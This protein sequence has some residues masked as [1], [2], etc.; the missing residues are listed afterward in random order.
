MQLIKTKFD[1]N[2][3]ETTIIDNK[4]NATRLS[5]NYDKYYEIK[6]MKLKEEINNQINNYNLLQNK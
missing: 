5:E 4:A 1:I 6:E 2:L 3:L